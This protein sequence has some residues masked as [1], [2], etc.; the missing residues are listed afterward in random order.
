MCTMYIY[1]VNVDVLTI[2]YQRKLE[3]SLGSGL[4][5]IQGFQGKSLH[6]FSP[7]TWHSIHSIPLHYCFNGSLMYT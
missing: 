4:T 3:L 1:S 5:M 2:S 7:N 6:V